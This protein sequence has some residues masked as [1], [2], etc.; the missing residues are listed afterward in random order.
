MNS[1]QLLFSLT[2]EKI[3]LEN[4]LGMNDTFAIGNFGPRFASNENT[5][6]L[7]HV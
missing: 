1:R 5:E 4:D 3:I 7:K 6:Y 2:L